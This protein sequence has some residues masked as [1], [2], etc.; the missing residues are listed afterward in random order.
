MD[1]NDFIIFKHGCGSDSEYTMEENNEM[2]FSDESETK[3]KS[4]AKTIFSTMLKS[5]SLGT[6][7]I[8]M[9]SKNLRTVH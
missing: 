6:L 4:I 7:Q 1:G 2:S 5:N 9:N 8:L 3:M